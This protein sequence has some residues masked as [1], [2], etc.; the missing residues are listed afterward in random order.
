VFF[1]LLIP[2]LTPVSLTES[3]S[4]FE[5]VTGLAEGIKGPSSDISYIREVREG[6]GLV[7]GQALV[8]SSLRI[9]GL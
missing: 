5:I 4:E 9:I 2:G 3:E 7:K 8:Y 1:Q 6:C